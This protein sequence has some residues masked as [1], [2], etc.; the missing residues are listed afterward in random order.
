M[1]I[2]IAYLGSAQYND[3]LRE[4]LQVEKLTPQ[5][6]KVHYYMGIAY[7]GKRLNDNA[8]DEFKKALSLQSD[9]PEAH[10]FLGTIYIEMGQWDNALESFK[11]ALSNILYETPDKALFNMGRAYHGKG[12]YE[13]A[14]SAY[15]EAKN[16]TPNSIPA[17]LLDNY[18]GV[19]YFAQGDMKNAVN[20]FNMSL[21][22]EPSLV[23]SRYWLGQCYI[24]M[25][26]LEKAK[27][28]FQAVI[29]ITPESELGIAAKKGLD[30][31]ESPR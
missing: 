7:Y 5:D 26:D 1:N 20:Y 19:T 17:P 23:E 4:L 6:P 12:D 31:I 21:K 8:I 15:R 11:N 22:Q 25:K 24:K 13:K 18:M 16:K 10:N 28:E 9:Y 3:A 2:G 29:K 14:L 30:S 27:A